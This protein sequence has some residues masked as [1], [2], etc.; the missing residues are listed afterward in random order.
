[1]SNTVTPFLAVCL[2]VIIVLI[3]FFIAF[4]IDPKN[5]DTSRTHVFIA[6]LAGLGIFVIFLFY[7][8]VIELQQEQIKLFSVQE[9]SRISNNILDIIF[10]EIQKSANDL[11]TFTTSLL[12]LMKCNTKPNPDKEDTNG[13]IMKYNL[14]YKI[15]TTFQDVMLS[16]NFVTIEPLAY[17]TNFLQRANSKKLYELWIVNRIDFNDK[18][19]KFGDLLFEYGLPI[20]E[21]TAIVYEQTAQ[22]LLNDERYKN[23]II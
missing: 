21:Q 4:M 1:M 23:L 9:T 5:Y 15:F 14:S 22:K 2:I 6:T 18:T 19:K 20:T 13:C 10:D 17:I 8:S 3:A 16:K 7:Y 12:P 11:P